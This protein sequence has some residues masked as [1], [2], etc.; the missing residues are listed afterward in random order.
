MAPVF[1]RAT[2]ASRVSVCPAS[3]GLSAPSR[4]AVEPGH[5]DP[6]RL[7]PGVLLRAGG[8]VDHHSLAGPGRADE[9]RGT[10]G[11]GEDFE[12]VVLLGAERPADALRDLTGSVLACNVADVSACGLGELCGAALDRLLLRAHRQ[13]G[14]PPALQG[15]HAPV[16]D[17]L[18]R[19]G[20]RLIR[21][22][23]SGGLLQHDRAQVALLEDGVLL[24]QLRLDPILD[25]ALGLWALGCA[26][27]PHRL[28]R[29]ESVIAGGLCPHSL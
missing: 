25:R 9:D 12:R 8:G 11:T 28:I 13:G 29:A 2:S 15:Q 17:H 19:D 27:Q 22:H 16:A 5:G 3:A 6:D 23:L 14:H 24:G 10:L 1:A 4:S 21:R 26:D 18:P 20:E 7:S